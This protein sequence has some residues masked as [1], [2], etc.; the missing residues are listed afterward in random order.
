[1]KWPGKEASLR[2]HVWDE[3]RRC[4]P[5]RHQGGQ[6][7]AEE[8]ISQRIRRREKEGL[9]AQ[10]LTNLCGSY[11]QV[12]ARWLADGGWNKGVLRT[13]RPPEGLMTRGSRLCLTPAWCDLSL[14]A[15]LSKCLLSGPFILTNTLVRGTMLGMP[16]VKRPIRRVPCQP[17]GQQIIQYHKQ[18]RDR[19]QTLSRK[20]KPP[21]P[22]TKTRAVKLSHVQRLLPAGASGDANEVGAWE[23]GDSGKPENL[24]MWGEHTDW[25]VVSLI[26]FKYI[27]KYF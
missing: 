17:L 9:T 8:V 21:L 13:F 16:G 14:S 20:Q 1:M 23:Q 3:K 6:L 15:S 11:H 10:L 25:F 12:S 22:P 5:H 4:Q 26:N 18:C 7:Q 19:Q 27:L 2:K 24:D